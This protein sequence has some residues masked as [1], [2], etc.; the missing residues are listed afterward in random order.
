MDESRVNAYLR[1]VSNVSFWITLR[2]IN[3]IGRLIKMRYFT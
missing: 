3:I 1:S 2:F